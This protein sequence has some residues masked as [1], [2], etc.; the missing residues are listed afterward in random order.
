MEI[1]KEVK[2]EEKIQPPVLGPFKEKRLKL[3]NNKTALVSE[4]WNKVFEILSN[5]KAGK[6]RDLDLV[7]ILKLLSKKTDSK[8]VLLRDYFTYFQNFYFLLEDINLRKEFYKF[9]AE[10]Y[11]NKGFINKTLY[12]E[13]IKELQDFVGADVL[14]LQEKYFEKFKNSS[15]KNLLFRLVPFLEK[16]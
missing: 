6:D 12:E 9:M 8:G 4:E 3:F 5:V 15:F 7:S 14:D 1:K 16:K 13:K 2:K 11:F 10:F